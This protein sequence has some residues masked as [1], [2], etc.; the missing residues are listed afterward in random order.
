M[1]RIL[2][3]LGTAVLAGCGGFTEPSDPASVYVRVVN[4]R[5][6]PMRPDRV[7]WYY[8]PESGRFDG[9][10]EARCISGGCTVW[11]VPVE[12]AGQA[13]VSASRSR[14]TDD[15]YC[16]YTGYDARPVQASADDPPTIV[17]RL[18]MRTMACA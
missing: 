3:A 12:A 13:Y 2:F 17:L 8:P 9:E 4:H 16:T 11:A 14:P 18:D 6:D 15:P 5:G 1:R 7:T 10:H